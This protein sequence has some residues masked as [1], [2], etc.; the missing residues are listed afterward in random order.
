MKRQPK[1]KAWALCGVLIGMKIIN[2]MIK[3]LCKA[4]GRSAAQ[5]EVRKKSDKKTSHGVAISSSDKR[6]LYYKYIDNIL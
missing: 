3:N 5:I 1:N 6:Y 2:S 4:T